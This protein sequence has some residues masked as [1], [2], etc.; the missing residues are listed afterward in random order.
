MQVRVV[1]TM[2]VR[3]DISLDSSV[4]M[5]NP[6][7]SLKH[8]S[9]EIEDGDKEWVL[10]HKEWKAEIPNLSTTTT[11]FIIGMMEE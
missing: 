6:K 8:N 9:N 5:G 7:P 10:M 3:L 4:T 2:Q 11:I 1:S